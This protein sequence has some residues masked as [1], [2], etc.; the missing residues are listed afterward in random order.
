[1]IRALV[2]ATAIV[3]A[4]PQIVHA[5]SS[6]TPDVVA[7]S[8]FGSLKA[9]QTGKAYQDLWRGTIMDRKQADVD[10]VITQTDVALKAYG[11]MAD[12]ELMEDEVLSPSFRIRTYLL[13]FDQGALFFKLQFYR[14]PKGWTVLNLD[15]RDRYAAL[16]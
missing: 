12:W 10:Y 15:F 6:A 4:A 2:L 3:L 9:G 7:D 1:M 5:Q 16:P 8:F 14:A 13:R 11:Q